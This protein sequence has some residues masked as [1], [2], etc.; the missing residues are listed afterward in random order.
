MDRDRTTKIIIN[1][2]NDGIK[3]IRDDDQVLQSLH[4]IQ[5]LWQLLKVSYTR[6]N[7]VYVFV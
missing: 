2:Y 1:I 6:W 7:C 5:L 4:I 3:N